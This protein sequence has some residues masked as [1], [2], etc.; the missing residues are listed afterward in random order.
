MTQATRSFGGADECAARF[1][2]E[3]GSAAG[4]AGLLLIAAFA[5]GASAPPSLAEPCGV[6]AATGAEATPLEALPEGIVRGRAEC[7]GLSR[8]VAVWTLPVDGGAADLGIRD[9]PLFRSRA[10]NPL[11]RVARAA[12]GEAGRLTLF[13][14]REAHTRTEGAADLP[15]RRPPFRLFG[16]FCDLAATEPLDCRAGAARIKMRADVVDTD[17]DGAL[18]RVRH[19]VSIW[20]GADRLQ[21]LMFETEHAGPPLRNAVPWVEV[22]ALAG[23][24]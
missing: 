15:D 24:L 3:G 20:D 11:V 21:V 7:E 8:P 14:R 23:R 16:T 4:R 1:L 6:V 19:E 22:L 5:F 2:R 12:V 13:K 10:A 17:R 9:R 18:D